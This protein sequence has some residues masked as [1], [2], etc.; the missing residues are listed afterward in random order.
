M[1]I[2][3]Q[4][5]IIS[6]NMIIPSPEESELYYKRQIDHLSNALLIDDYNPDINVET[7][8]FNFATKYKWINKG[9]LISGSYAALTLSAAVNSGIT[10]GFKAD[11]VDIYFKSMEDAKEFSVLNNFGYADFTHPMCAYAINGGMKFNFIF[12]IKYDSPQHLI[13]KFDI[14]AC[15]MAIDPNSNMSYAV[16]GALYDALYRDIVYNPVPRA[17]SIR[18]LVKYIEKGFKIDK[19]QRLFFAELVRSDLYSPELEAITAY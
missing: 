7:Y 15:S 18:R 8:Q 17:V 6:Y 19:N 14:R 10:Y 13:S 16:T 12:G 2:W 5:P 11:D 3:L 9:E 4:A 1:S